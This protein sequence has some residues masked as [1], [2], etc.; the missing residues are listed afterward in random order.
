M[1]MDTTQTS[2]AADFVLIDQRTAS[3]AGA[4]LVAKTA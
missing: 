1:S 2:N 3:T 4:V